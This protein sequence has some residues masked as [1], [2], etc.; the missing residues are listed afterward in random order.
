MYARL[1]FLNLKMNQQMHCPFQKLS[2]LYQRLKSSFQ[3]RSV[4]STQRSDA[5]TFGCWCKQ[6]KYVSSHFVSS[7][8]SFRI[9]SSIWSICLAYLWYQ[10]GTQ[11]AYGRPENISLLL[12]VTKALHID[13]ALVGVVG[14][15]WTLDY[16]AKVM[17]KFGCGPQVNQFLL[18]INLNWLFQIK[19]YKFL[20]QF[21][22]F[23]KFAANFVWFT[24]FKKIF[25]WRMSA[26]GVFYWMSMHISFTVVWILLWVAVVDFL[27]MKQESRKISVC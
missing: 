18:Y 1:W 27:V 10:K 25:Y 14:L 6:G 9:K 13:G 20:T 22:V 24:I 19:F 12:T 5:R 23:G 7:K 8:E 4:L 21:L 17:R 15:E 26:D 3:W 11:S 16:M 2:T